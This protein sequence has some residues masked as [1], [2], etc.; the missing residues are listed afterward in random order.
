MDTTNV[1]INITGT[2]VANGRCTFAGGNPITVEYGDVFISDI[3]GDRYRQ[4]LNYGVSCSGDAG[5]KTIQL[6]LAGIG[7]DFDG[8][9]LGTNAK[10]LGIKLLRDNSQMEPGKWY[11]LNPSS[12]P[13]LEGV[14][15]KQSGADFSNGQEF[16]AS[17]TLKV[18]YN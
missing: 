17:A 10:G 14:L 5:G 7:A 9:L 1:K 16:S 15:V 18:A 6:Q 12:P 3:A 2:V 13:K 11:D 8:T 4:P